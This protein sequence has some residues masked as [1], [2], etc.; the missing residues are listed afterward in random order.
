MLSL[1]KGA[2]AQV[3]VDNTLKPLLVVED[4]PGIQKQLKWSFEGYQVLLAGDR[5]SA[6]EQLQ[7]NHIPVVTLDLGLPPD[8]ANAS[9]G[10]ATLEEI[11]KIASHTKVIVVTGNDDRQN[12]LKAISLGAYDFYQKPIEP[13][14]LGLIVDRA[15]QLYELEEENRR[16]ATEGGNSPLDGIIGSSA[17]MLAACRLVEKV[18]PTEATTLVLG[19]SG[20]GKELIAQALHRLSPRRDKS[21][22]ALN[23]AAIPDNL[24]E[25]EL[26]GYEKGAFTGAV[27]QTKGKIE[28]A[29]GGTLFLDE[30]GDMPMPLQ[31][32]ML[33]FLQERVIER[34]GGRKTI[35]IDTRIICATHRKLDKLIKEGEFR[36]DLF[37]RISEIAIKIPALRERDTDKIL[38]AQTFLNNYSEKNGRSFRGFTESARAGIDSYEWPGNVRELENRIK[39][40][41]V[42]AEGNQIT[43]TDLGFSVD[44]NR[45]QSLNLRDAREQVERQ[46]IQR[47]LSIHNNNVTHA[48]EA[49]GISR[50]SLYSLIKKLGMPE[51]SK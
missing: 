11:L 44:E 2:I 46:V 49:L 14:V 31:A 4:N 26:F 7:N 15:Y 40:A 24:L 10:L 9:E 12:A 45:L 51:P 3:M 27:K 48:A 35:E 50:P 36:E 21:F 39:R 32:K 5:V 23:C 19:E 34:L 16:L 25:S 37:F 42:L 38:L 8:Q 30:I 1:H 29:S 41:V 20:T 18:G 13:D 33:R 47:A 6:I 28:V 43:A 22:V 17:P